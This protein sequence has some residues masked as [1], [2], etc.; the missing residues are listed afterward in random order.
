M[1]VMAVVCGVAGWRFASLLVNEGGPW[2]VFTKIRR[3][4]GIPD[5][6]EIPDTFWAGLLSCFMCASVWTTA[7]MGFLWVVGLEWAVATF[8]AMTIAI[9]VEKG[10]THHE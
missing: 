8:A 5:E 2:N 10:I 9:A 3:A 1:I 6:G 7:I 4:A